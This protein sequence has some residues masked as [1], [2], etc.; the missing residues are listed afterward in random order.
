MRIA[1]P[2]RLRY[3]E[4]LDEK[5]I[6]PN[7]GKTLS[8]HYDDLDNTTICGLFVD[9]ELASTIRVHVAT[10]DFPDFPAMKSPDKLVPE[11]DDGRV[12]VEASRH[13][14]ADVFSRAYPN[15]MPF[16]T[17]RMTWLAAEYFGA[18]LY[19]AA[20]RRE[21][22]AFYRRVFDGTVVCEPRPYNQLITPLSLMT[23]DYQARR[24]WVHERYPIFR[25]SLF[26]RRMLLG[27]AAL[28]AVATGKGAVEPV[29]AELVNLGEAA[30]RR[31][32]LEAANAT[33]S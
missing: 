14:T 9:G 30:E 29:S 7:F 6:E 10:I 21:H 8:D 17:I 2:F 1:R 33:H 12:I 19:I 20:V 22:Q 28:P 26:E 16:M 31:E 5:A 15:L 24:N 32:G 25:S 4:Y 3:D 13:A 23:C 27:D 11:L 18:D